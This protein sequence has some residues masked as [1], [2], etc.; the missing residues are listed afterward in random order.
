MEHYPWYDHYDPH[1]PRTLE[2][3]PSITIVDVIRETATLRPKHPALWYKGRVISYRTLEQ[4]SDA[5]ATAL[6]VLGVRKGDRVALLLPNIPQFVIGELALWKIGA[7][8][9]PM[10]PLYTA[11]ELEHAFNEVQAELAIVLTP[12][13]AKVKSIQPRTSL[14]RI[15]ATN[16]KEYL[17]TYLRLL[18]TV[19]KEKREGHRIRI[20]AEDLWFQELIAQHRGE[21]PPQITITPDDP[22]LILFTGGTTGR[23]KAALGAHKAFIM[24]GLQVRTWFGDQLEEWKDVFLANL[25]LFHVF[26]GVGTQS[27]AFLGRSTMALV[28]NPRDIGD[29]IATIEKTRATFMTAVPTLFIALMQH[30]RVTQGKADLSSL[31]A[32]ISGAAPLLRQTKEDFERLT[33]ARIVEGYALTESMMASTINP[34]YGVNKV[35]SVGMPVPDVKIRIVDPE[36]G[37]RELPTGEIGEVTMWAPQLMIEYWQRPEE[38]AYTLRNGWLF[39]GDLG[40]LDEDGYLFIVD[41]KKDVIKVSG[42]QVWPRE[43]EEVIARH[44]AVAEVGVAGIP[45]PYQG[46]AVKAWIVLKEGHTATADEIRAY[47]RQYLAPYKVPKHVEFRAELPKSAVGKLLRRELRRQA[48]QQ[49]GASQHQTDEGST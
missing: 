22:A 4:E 15:I 18:F 35:G 33:G 40:Y 44:P 26:A 12:F 13:Y 28:P 19:L 17:P 46:E 34:V 1:V 36:T 3:Y 2:P 5:L 41:R 23:S 9:T 45:D 11:P 6:Y 38:T 8:S 25:P 29:Q 7:I 21:A 49:E 16:V 10:N 20:A 24:T 30:P 43:V 31:K 32:C 48:V 37:T 42:L 14:R 39:T 47:C 27:V